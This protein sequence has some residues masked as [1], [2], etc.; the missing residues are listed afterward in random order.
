MKKFTHVMLLMFL[1]LVTALYAQ[2]KNDERIDIDFR[3]QKVSDIVLSVAK[4]CGKSVS[5]DDTVAG[6]A[7]FH[8]EDKSFDVAIRRFCDANHIFINVVDDIYYLTKIRFEEKPEGYFIDCENV[9]VEPFLRELSRFTHTTIMNDPLPNVPVTVREDSAGVEDVLRLVMLRLTGY[10]LDREGEGFFIGKNSSRGGSGRGEDFRIELK[11]S[12]YTLTLRKGSLAAV[13]DALFKKAGNEY[14]LLLKNSVMLENLYYS[15]KDFDSLLRLILEQ[16]SCDYAVNSEIYYVFEVQKKDVLKKLKD[17]TAVRLVN[18]NAD[19]VMSLFPTDLNAGAF[20]KADKTTNTLYVTGSTGETAPILDFLSAI[21]VPIEDR[22]YRCF[23]LRNISVAAAVP[24][25]PKSMLYGDITVIP[26]TMSFVTQ[27]T[28]E[29][30]QMLLEY[31]ALIDIRN[32][33]RPVRLRYIKSDEL[34]KFLPPSVHKENLSLT[35]DSTLIFFTGPEDVYQSF[36]KELALM[37]KPKQQVCYQVLVI[38]RQRSHGLNSNSKITMSKLA[39]SENDRKGLDTMNWMATLGN[40]FSINFDIVSF[41]GIQFAALFN[42]ELGEGRSH[43]LADTRLN[44]ISGQTINFSNTS[45]FRY[46]D[47]VPDS[48]KGVYS[49]TTREISSGLV[50][51]INGWVSGDDMITVDVNAQVSNQGTVNGST[52]DTTNP[53]GTT[54]KKVSTNVRTESG[55]PI[56]I[57][58]LLQ[59]DKEVTVKKVPLLGS[60]PLLGHLFRKEVESDSETEFVIYLVPFVEKPDN[61][62]V[63]HDKRLRQYYE[64]YVAKEK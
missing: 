60:I 31:L 10:S 12:L 23:T 8:F 15:D 4:M 21:D 26:D 47:I 11:D 36:L 24:L 48:N 59:S 51:S 46:R 9:P 29:R 38:Q 18:I 16:A 37:D 7:S 32:E 13:M 28:K 33:A 50:L 56:V 43:V 62:K 34:M 14:S 45:T 54:E 6:I 22:Y 1:F 52:T 2:E 61:G 64:E 42:A 40:L 27:V 25:I 5:L 3:N 53:P 41:L 57:S 63:N 44:G 58:G 20:V 17:T 39:G 49:S 35:D 19:A 55:T 30:E